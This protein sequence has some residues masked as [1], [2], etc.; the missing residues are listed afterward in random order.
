MVQV[1]TEFEDTLALQQKHFL[2]H[3]SV[4]LS[5]TF[6]TAVEGPGQVGVYNGLPSLGGHGLYGAVKL[7]SSVVNKIVYP[8]MLLQYSRHQR[9]DLPETAQLDM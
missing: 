2:S 4:C 9:F 3:C 5:L 6:F 1:C 7:P 8:S